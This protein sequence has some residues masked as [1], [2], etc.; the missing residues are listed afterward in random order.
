MSSLTTMEKKRNKKLWCF[1]PWGK[2]VWYD[3]ET[4]LRCLYCNFEGDWNSVVCLRYSFRK[5]ALLEYILFSLVIFSDA[6][7]LFRTKSWDFWNSSD[8]HYV[9]LR[10]SFKRLGFSYGYVFALEK[11][12]SN[13]LGNNGT[14]GRRWW[15][16]IWGFGTKC[17]RECE[18]ESGSILVRV[19]KPEQVEII[20]KFEIIMQ[21]FLYRE[22]DHVNT[23]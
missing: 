19:L 15:H 11:Y 14:V 13:L 2:C 12:T 23:F 3:E 6:L 18:V 5:I 16:L 22:A 7:C 10:L 17:G 4:I 9:T 20:C 21:G 1:W 8:G